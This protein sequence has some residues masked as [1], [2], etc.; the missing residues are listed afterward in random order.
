[1]S[2]KRNASDQGIVLVKLKIVEALDFLN[3]SSPALARNEIL[4]IAETGKE[5]HSK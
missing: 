2:G 1:M 3:Y 4:N 5:K